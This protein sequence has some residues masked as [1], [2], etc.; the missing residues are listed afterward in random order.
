MAALER[1]AA[2]AQCLIV[3]L[4]RVSMIDASGA[5]A[6]ERLHARVRAKNVRLVLSGILQAHRRF[7]AVALAPL[8]S[9]LVVIASYLAYGMVAQDA[10]SPSDVPPAAIWILA[11]GTTL[12]VVVLSLVNWT[13]SLFGHNLG[14]EYYG[15]TQKA[16]TLAIVFA[17]V[18]IVVG[19]LTFIIDFD[20][21]EQGIRYG[22][23]SRRGSSIISSGA[24]GGV[25]RTMTT[26]TGATGCRSRS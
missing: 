7:L 26:A 19:A 3:D 23:P 2:D 21:V 15:P 17:L 25:D 16:G 20:A 18:C 6:F 22:L 1:I 9:S 11:G 5:L 10:T 12:G 14:Y 4:K 13:L 24:S 8:L